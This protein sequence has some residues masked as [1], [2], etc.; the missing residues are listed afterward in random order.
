[1]T[2]SEDLVWKT[3]H[4]DFPRPHSWGGLELRCRQGHTPRP[5]Q[6]WAVRAP[7]TASGALQRPRCLRTE[8]FGNA[9]HREAPVHA[10]RTPREWATGVG[11]DVGKLDP[12]L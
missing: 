1:M 11:E 6:S 2:G 12:C 9:N 5:P 8:G 10:T 7:L 3:R 4:G